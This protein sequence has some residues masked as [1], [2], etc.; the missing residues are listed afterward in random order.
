MSVTVTM[1]ALGESVTEGTVTRWL[2]AV[3]DTVVADEPLLEVSTDKVDTE[4]PAPA[5][6][7]LLSITVGEDETVEVGAELGVIGTSDEAPAAAAPEAPAPRRRG[8]R[9]LR[10]PSSR[11]RHRSPRLPH[12]SSQARRCRRAVAGCRSQHPGAHARTGRE[13]HRGH[14]HP[15]AQGRRRHRRRRRAPA[16]GLHRQGRHRDPRPR[17][18]RP[19]V[20]H[21]GRG[22]DR[23]GRRRAR[24]HR[25]R[26]GSRTCCP[27]HR[28]PQLRAPAA[29]AAP[30]AAATPAPAPRLAAASAAAPAPAPAAEPAGNADAYVT[31]L[32]RR[33]AAQHGVDLSTVT[34]TGVGGRIRKSDVLDAALKA[35][36]A[37]A[38]VPAA[39]AP[40][41]APPAAATA[42]GRRRPLRGRTEKMSR[43]RKVIAERMVESLQVSAQLTSVVE[44]DVTRIANLRAKV[45]ARLRGPR[46]RQ[47]VV[48]AVLLQGLRRGAQAVPAGQRHP[49][50]GRGHGHLLRGRAPRRR[51]RQRA[52]PAGAGHP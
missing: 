28:L 6:G 3:G 50:H 51:R 45:K 14:G 37:A 33:L 16:R 27:A 23:R 9:R 34:G 17:L 22:L 21:R 13:R 36:P 12:R 2:K 52:R 10:R 1:P 11:L 32:V 49:Q 7:V 24:R 26:V 18:R 15:L 47:A 41:A 20:H 38:P 25:R 48:P 35:K 4:I 29:P 31:P 8:A 42:R 5:S 43:L 46:G 40:A 44:V 19:A 30:V 39:A